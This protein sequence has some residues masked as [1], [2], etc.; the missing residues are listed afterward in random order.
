MKKNI[1]LKKLLIIYNKESKIDSKCVE[2]LKR[3]NI[4]LTKI[5]STGKRKENLTNKID[6]WNGDYIIHL[7]SYYKLTKNDLNRA[8]MA[9]NFHPGP[10]KYPGS[11][12]Y[13]KALLNLDKKFG[14]TVH[15]MNDKIDNG[16]IIGFYSFKINSNFDLKKLI[17]MTDH[18]KFF[19]FK[20]IIKTLLNKN[21]ENRLLKLSNN[22]KF[23]WSKK[24]GKI[25]DIDNLQRIRTFISKKKLEKIIRSTSIGN[26]N[27][28]IILHGYKFVLKFNS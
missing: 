4:R 16:K 22:N 2:F 27:P 7:G 13:S 6:T 1:K 17:F 21:G 11:G 9:I 26:H 15:F 18:Y 10:P 24:R 23:K 5:F 14:V 28:F 20:K 3:F 25:T 8:R 12:G 19:V